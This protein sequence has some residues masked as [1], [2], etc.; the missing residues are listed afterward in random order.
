MMKNKDR[1]TRDVE[2]KRESVLAKLGDILG[3]RGVHG[4]IKKQIELQ[5]KSILKTDILLIVMW[6][7]WTNRNLYTDIYYSWIKYKYLL[8]FKF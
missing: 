1:K 4:F 8:H 3:S 6:F 5:I 7:G 2:G